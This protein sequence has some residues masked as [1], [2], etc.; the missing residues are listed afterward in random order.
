MM[1]MMIDNKRILLNNI[2]NEINKEY[3]ELYLEYLSDEIAIER[4]DFS[5]EFKNNLLVT[6]TKDI[7]NYLFFFFDYKVSSN[8]Y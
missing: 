4:Y 1:M 8:L 7:G 5:K 6:F 2:P 3:L